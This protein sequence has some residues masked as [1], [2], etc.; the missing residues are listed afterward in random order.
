MVKIESGGTSALYRISMAMADK[1]IICKAIDQPLTENCE[2]GLPISIVLANEEGSCLIP[3]RIIGISEKGEIVAASPSGPIQKAERRIFPRVKIDSGIVLRLQFDRCNSRYKC[4][5]V[6]DISGSGIGVNVYAKNPIHLG[7]TVQI[8][9]ELLS[10]QNK[11]I[12]AG[13]VVHCTVRNATS[14]EYQLGIKFSQ[15]SSEDQQK[16]VKFVAEEQHRYEAHEKQCQQREQLEEQARK[17]AKER[18]S[19]RNKPV[20]KGPAKP[21]GSGSRAS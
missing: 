18:K 5:Q 9:I 19:A 12:A 3:A 16:L 6:Y 1:T 20:T 7:N 4:M 10:R 17:R 11:I 15:I 13:K 21:G 2:V 8:E 14:R